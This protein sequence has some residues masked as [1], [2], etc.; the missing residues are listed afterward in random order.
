MNV[1]GRDLFVAVEI[2]LVAAVYAK[3]VVNVVVR[4]SVVIVET[5]AVGG[6][7]LATRSA[8]KRHR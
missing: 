3:V 4:G 2:A 5:A 7:K 6:T 8:V 1:V